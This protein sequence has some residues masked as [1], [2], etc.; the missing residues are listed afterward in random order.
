MPGN[1]GD[2]G[3]DEIIGQHAQA[4]AAQ[5]HGD[6]QLIA[7]QAQHVGD[8]QGAGIG[9]AE[10]IGAA[11]QHR[12]GAEGHGLEHVGAAADAAIHQQRQRCQPRASTMRGSASAVG[13][14]CRGC[15]RRGWRRSLRPPAAACGLAGVVGVED[16][17]EDEGQAGVGLQPGDIV[18]ARCACTQ[19]IVEERALARLP[20]AL[21]WARRKLGP[22]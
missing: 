14:A 16:A 18:P 22:G 1:E 12:V 15:A 21:V 9:E 13:G 4:A 8:A 20:R 6:F 2:G 10:D 19:Q 5:G 3:R 17:L 11:D 7:Q